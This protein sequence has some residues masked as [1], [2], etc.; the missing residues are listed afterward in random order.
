LEL[1]AQ[2]PEAYGFL[3]QPARYKVCKGGRGA[4]RSWSFARALLILGLS[5]PLRVLCAREFQNSIKDSVHKLLADQIDDM[6]LHGAYEVQD[7]VIKGRN[8]TEISFKGLRHNITGIKSFE[9]ADIVWVEE[10]NTVSKASWEILIPTIRKPDSEIWLTFNPELDTD[11]TYVRFVLNTPPNAVVKH[12]TW[13]DNPWFPEVLMDEMAACKQRS[14]DDYNTIWE[15]KTRKVLQG[16]VYADELRQADEDGRITRVPYN[17]AKPVDTYWDLGWADHVAIWFTQSFPNEF[18]VIDF[19]ADHLKKMSDYLKVLQAK[20]YVYGIDHLPHDGDHELLAA[21]GRSIRSMMTSAGRKVRIVPNLSVDAG[22]RAT[23]E[24]FPL[25][26][27]DEAKC[28]DGLNSLRR[29]RW[30]VSEQNGSY[31]RTPVHDENSHGADAF[32]MMGVAIKAPK[33]KEPTKPK[34]GRAFVSS[35]WMAA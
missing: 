33:A 25:C 35:G 8:G 6:N 12:T 28:R 2:I 32:R 29:Y 7:T 9:G 20:Q 26:W 22:I 27:F 16:A 5:K 17:P 19:H 24:V 11:E 31:Q 4:G 23:R 10:A 21:D 30:R 34:A 1:R 3:F 15:G 13:R 14:I 18:H